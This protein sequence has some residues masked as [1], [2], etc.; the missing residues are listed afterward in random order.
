MSEIVLK[1][2]VKAYGTTPV[3]HGVDLHIASGEFCVFVG[4]SGCGKSTLLRM[5]AGLEGISDGEISIGG[6]LVNDLPPRERDIAMVF[7]DYALYPHKT[8]FEN[9]AFGL[10]L[11][12]RPSAEIESRVREAAQILQIDHLLE[13]RPGQ[14]SGGQRQRVAMGRAI[15]RNPKAF[16]FDEPLS[17]LDAQLR[18]EMR[19]EI[20]K[21][22]KR[23]RNTVVYV[24]HDQVEAMTLADK[25][26]VLSAG[27]IVQ[28]GTPDE[29]YNRPAA[30]FVA[31][32]TGS[33]PMNFLPCSIDADGA[34]ILLDGGIRLPVPQARRAVC[35]KLAGRRL[36]FGIRPEH[37]LAEA[38]GSDVATV[39]A[40]VQL[41]E[42]LGSDTLGLLRIGTGEITGRFAPEAPLSAGA[43]IQ[44]G[45]AMNKFH[46]FAP[47][48]GDA[49]R[50]PGW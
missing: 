21:L 18:S 12:K 30:K 27:R 35:S 37:I 38:V 45:F 36:D 11:R 17:N 41:V 19:V 9:M 48:T 4:P 15:V 49:I 31:G 43:T 5:I 33:P 39:P 44:A 14:L 25:I 29:I 32:F 46:L 13:R 24:T 2:V 42:P 7:Q 23:L 8:V 22:H 50:D 47:D 20:N 28:V 16:L 6:T 1:N 34:A 40:H 26:V 3:I 10:R